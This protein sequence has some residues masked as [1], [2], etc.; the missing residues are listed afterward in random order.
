MDL[1]HKLIKLRKK[2]TWTQAYA[3][4]VIDIQQSYLSKLENGRH[5]PSPEVLDK[6]CIA[7]D[8][9][10]NKLLS[11]ELKKTNNFIFLSLLCAAS[12]SIILIGYFALLYPQT[13]YTYKISPVKPLSKQESYLKIHLTDQYLGEYYIKGIANNEYTYELVAE[14]EIFRQE[15]RLIVAIGVVLTLL[16]LVFFIVV[17]K[18]NTYRPQ[19]LPD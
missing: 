1:G 19:K 10:L 7:Y 12:F 4:N 17:T 2:K 15:N 5:L 14:K 13:Y 18:T 16:S 8:I 6:L 9:S 11:T 3:A